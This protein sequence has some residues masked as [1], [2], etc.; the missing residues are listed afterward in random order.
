VNIASPGR[1]CSLEK[2]PQPCAEPPPSVQIRVAASTDAYSSAKSASPCLSA[3]ASSGGD[4]A[5]AKSVG[6]KGRPSGRTA[7]RH[8]VVAEEPEARRR[9]ASRGGGRRILRVEMCV[10]S[11]EASAC[12]SLS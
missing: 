4:G 11:P 6:A 8:S 1:F 7:I 12:Q 5:S 9:R 10:R 3:A 2:K